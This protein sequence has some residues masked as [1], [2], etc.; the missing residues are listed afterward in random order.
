VLSSIRYSL[1]LDPRRTG[2]TLP[3]T[4]LDSDG[5]ILGYRLHAAD[6]PGHLTER[7][8]ETRIITR[9]LGLRRCIGNNC[10]A[11]A[12]V[13]QADQQPTLACALRSCPPRDT[14]VFRLLVL[15]DHVVE[16]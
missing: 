16:K 4:W 11:D 3:S 5:H 2:R 7:D 8:L 13:W 9:F 14:L 6:K 15:C 1:G 10:L 12:E